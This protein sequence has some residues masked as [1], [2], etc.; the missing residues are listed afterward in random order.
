MLNITFVLGNQRG[1][2]LCMQKARASGSGNKYTTR[3]P[4]VNY[5]KCI[6]AIVVNLLIVNIFL[7]SGIYTRY[8]PFLQK[9]KPFIKTIKKVSVYLAGYMQTSFYTSV[10]RSF[11]KY[12][13]LKAGIHL[14][15]YVNQQRNVLSKNHDQ[16]S[17][18]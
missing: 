8:K 11:D 6:Y 9:D 2:M 18:T 12:T 14:L 4:L 3:I 16:K 17:R 10:Q 7:S 15:L 13:C 5:L 1:D